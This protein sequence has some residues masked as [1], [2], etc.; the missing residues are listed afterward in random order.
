MTT[1]ANTMNQDLQTKQQILAEMRQ[2]EKRLSSP[3]MNALIENESNQNRRNQ[4]LDMRRNYEEA[5]KNLENAV[6]EKISVRLKEQENEL[7]KAL[8][9]LTSVLNKINNTV[10]VLRTVNLVTSIVGRIVNIF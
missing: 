1:M 9:E 10:A 6:L 3:E 2:H 5:R 8:N 7:Q 4:L